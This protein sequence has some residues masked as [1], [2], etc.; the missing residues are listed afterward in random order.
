MGEYFHT[1]RNADLLVDGFQTTLLRNWSYFERAPD[2]AELFGLLAELV[3]GLLESPLTGDQFSLLLRPLLTWATDVLA[4]PQ[5]GPVRRAARGAR[6]RARQGAAGARGRVPRARHA[7]AQ[8]RPAGAG[9]PRARA[10]LPRA[11]PRAA[12]GRVPPRARPARRPG[13]GALAGRAPHRPGG[14]RR[15]VRLPHRAPARHA[16][17]RAGRGAGRPPARADVPRVLDGPG[18]GHR[19][20]VPGREPR[21]PVRRLPLLPQGRDARLPAEGGHGRPPRRGQADD[22]AGPAHRRHP[23]PRAPHGVLPRPRQRVPAHALR[24]LRGDRGRHRRGRQ[25]QGGR[26]PHRGHPVL[27]VPVPGHPRRHRRVGDGGQSLPPAQDPLL[28][29]HHRV[30]PGAVRA[31]GRRPQRA[32]QAGRRVHRRH[33]PVPARRHALPRRGHPPHL[34]RRQAAAAHAARLLQRGRGG[35]R[36]ARR[37]DADRR[38][39]RAARHA[40]ALPAQAG[41]RGV[42]QPDGPVQ[43][44]G[45]ALLAHPRPVGPRAVRVGQHARGGP[46]RAAVGGRPARGAGRAR[47][48]GRTRRGRRRAARGARGAPSR[49]PRGAPGAGRRRRP[50]RAP[51]AVAR[52]RVAL[53]V[54]THQLLAR[55]YSLAA[56]GRGRGRLAPPQPGRPHASPLRGRAGALAGA[57]RPAHQGRAARR[58]AHRARASQGRHP[59]AGGR[60]RDREHLPEAA[61]RRRHPVDLRQLQRAA[62]RRPRALVP[63]GEPHRPAARRRRGGGRR[64]LRHARLPAPHGDGPAALRARARRRRR[65]L[66]RARRQPRHARGELL[67]AQLHLP[68]VP[69]RVPVPRPTA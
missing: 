22:A 38:D 9:A 53:L 44:R 31:A 58:R 19:R 12:R 6:R 3:V 52:R 21:G 2:R 42:L 29:A 45:A 47:R 18:G 40:H 4:G 67:A 23:H 69:E 46:R 63:R 66:A 43:P 8:P 41:A 32:A 7:P 20:A 55:K 49:R 39:L 30:Q 16:A 28:D 25:R 13:V 33:R 14:R 10:R 1:F 57:P 26:P 17:R 59:R 5:R 68:P 50:R 62:V 24:L 64:A 60:G 15:A 36:A 56:D 54:R 34:L 35:G 37:L 11:V 65:R 27:E 51:A 61:H 48:G